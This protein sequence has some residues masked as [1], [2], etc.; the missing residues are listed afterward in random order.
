M[1]QERFNNINEIDGSVES[2]RLETRCRTIFFDDRFCNGENAIQARK[3][4]IF[5]RRS[6]EKMSD[7]AEKTG[8]SAGTICHLAGGIAGLTPIEKYDGRC[9]TDYLLDEL[10]TIVEEKLG[11]ESG[12]G[13]CDLG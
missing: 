1:P 3:Y 2:Y 8:V 5:L 11:S 6:G 13:R 10:K 12:A 4:L 7:L 9:M